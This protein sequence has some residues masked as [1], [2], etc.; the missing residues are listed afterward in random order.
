[1]VKPQPYKLMI[2]TLTKSKAKFLKFI[3]MK[4]FVE[5]EKYEISFE[6]ENIGEEVFPGGI[7]YFKIGWP[8][9]Q[10]V[11]GHFMIPRLRRNKNYGTPKFLTD[12]LSDGYG[13]VS[14]KMYNVED[15]QGKSWQV[16]LYRKRIKPYGERVQDRIDTSASVHSIRGKSWEEI[17]EF[18]ALIAAAISLAI[19]ALEKIYDYVLNLLAWLLRWIA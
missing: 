10:V 13:L 5:G 6:L 3:P 17:Y 2:D 9:Q 12:V 4:S 19:I 7:L 1:M 11:R 15:E 18:W 8:S 16:E 14:I